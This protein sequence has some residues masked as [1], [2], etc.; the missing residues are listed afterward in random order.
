MTETKDER[1]R[2]SWVARNR[3]PIL[4]VLGRVLPPRGCVLEVASGTGEHAAFF[5]PRLAGLSWTPT[6]VDADS[7]RSIRAWR[8]HA[9]AA[10]LLEP[11]QLDVLG[12]DWP[13]GPFDVIVAMNL[14]HIAP[15]AVCEGLMRGA[16]SVLCDGGL[17]YLYGPFFVGGKEPAPG[18]LRFDED[19][20]RRDPGWGVR[21]L[22]DVV[23]VAAQHRL[24]LRETVDM[25]S[26]N[27]SVFFEKRG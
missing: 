18:N 23:D 25:P 1:K 19:L 9:A 10:N 6:D 21:K 3:Q 14:I 11:L 27:L 20:R 17:L 5:A 26:N 12:D 15:F 13:S 2:A 8:A 22:E 7:L 16:G 4:D 24:V